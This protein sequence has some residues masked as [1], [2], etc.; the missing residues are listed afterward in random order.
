MG[1]GARKRG[2]A[3]CI[4]SAGTCGRGQRFAIRRL[5]DRS[6][7][8]QLRS[9]GS[10]S[11]GV[12]VDHSLCCSGDCLP[13]PAPDKSLSSCHGRRRWCDSAD[14]LLVSMHFFLFFFWN[15][16]VRRISLFNCQQINCPLFIISSF[17]AGS[18]VIGGGGK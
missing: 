9:G 2:W 13:P 7:V 4:C 17:H 15:I 12:P 1:V 18:M 14:L 3:T 8:A 6:A 16:I 10:A 11:R 5:L